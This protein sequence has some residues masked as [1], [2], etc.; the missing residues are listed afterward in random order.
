MTISD[1]VTRMHT[2]T[3]RCFRLLDQ[4]RALKLASKKQQFRSPS[5]KG[6]TT[7]PGFLVSSLLIVWKLES[8]C[9]SLGVLS[10]LT[11]LPPTSSSYCEDKYLLS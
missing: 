3:A 9:K 2:T 6:R 4:Y 11:F 7:E 1:P 5:W 10:S 8:L